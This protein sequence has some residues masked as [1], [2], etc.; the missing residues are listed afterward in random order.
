MVYE[1]HLFRVFTPGQG[2]HVGV[3]SARRL[4]RVRRPPRSR[5]ILTTTKRGAVEAEGWFR[6]R[7]DIEVRTR[8]AKLGAA[9]RN[10]LYRSARSIACGR[11]RLMAGNLSVLLQALTGLVT[12]GHAHS[13]TATPRPA[14][15]PAASSDTPA[16]TS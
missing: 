9:L 15:H 5:R 7:T 16:D 6:R 14:V 4:L 12:A 13:E 8:D 2:A 3:A 10:L 1:G 11:G